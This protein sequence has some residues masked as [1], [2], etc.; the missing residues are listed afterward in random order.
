MREE[1]TSSSSIFFGFEQKGRPWTKFSL[2][3]ITLFLITNK[4]T[5]FAQHPSPLFLVS[6]QQQNHNKRPIVFPTRH[7]NIHNSVIIRS[8][9]RGTWTSQIMESTTPSTPIIPKDESNEQQEAKEEKV[10]EDQWNPQ[11]YAEKARFVAD[12]GVPIIKLLNPERGQ[13]LL[14]LGCG[15]GALTVQLASSAPSLD[16]IGIDKSPNLI[17]RAQQEYHSSAGNDGDNN[18]NSINIEYLEM[19]AHQMPFHEEFDGVMSNAA[20]HWMK[21]PDRVVD[22]VYRALKPGGTFAGEFGGHGNVRSIVDAVEQTLLSSRDN[23]DDYYYIQSTT[24]M[25]TSSFP[26]CIRDMCPWYFPDVAEYTCV[27]ERHGFVVQSME[28]FPR[29]V[30]LSEGRDIEDWLDV[31]GPTYL[32]IVPEEKREEFLNEVREVLRP[33][34]YDSSTGLW[35]VDYVRL[36]FLAYKAPTAT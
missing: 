18:E 31:F 11:S 34:L 12:L 14:D 7:I 8:R 25:T 29:P 24:N 32:S 17:E 16:I 1:H 28:L 10:K 4:T 13:R 2:I 19:D 26:E 21:E 36:R 22:G 33:K 6:S 9:A 30:T 20:L 35:S 27:L 5:G 3:S 23:N 15:D